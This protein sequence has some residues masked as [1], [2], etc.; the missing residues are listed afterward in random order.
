MYLHV[1]GHSFQPIS[2]V[3]GTYLYEFVVDVV[4]NG[5]FFTQFEN[6]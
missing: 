2:F 4:E 1:K 3:Y 6:R 5:K